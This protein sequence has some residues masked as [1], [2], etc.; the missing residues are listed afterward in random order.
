MGS[1]RAR[2]LRFVTIAASVGLALRRGGPTAAERVR[3]LVGD[4]PV[5]PGLR[6]AAAQAPAAWDRGEVAP[7]FR[8]L[9]WPMLDDR[10]ARADLDTRYMRLRSPACDCFGR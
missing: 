7:A 6:M 9:M 4:T 3:R 5:H 10:T 2:P 1:G 8:L